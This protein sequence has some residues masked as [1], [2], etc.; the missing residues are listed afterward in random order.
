MKAENPVALRESISACCLE[1]K[2]WRGQPAW[3]SGQPCWDR[4][5]EIGAEPS[6]TLRSQ[7]LSRQLREPNSSSENIK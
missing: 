3:F 4:E 1:T 7:A 6:R 5:V 2:G